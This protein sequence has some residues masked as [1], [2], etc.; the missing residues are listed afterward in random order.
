MKI[1]IAEDEAII[2]I[3]LYQVLT[4][5]GYLPI[6]PAIDSAE[7]IAAIK[8]EKPTFAIVDIH[9]GEY[10][11]GFE[12]AAVLQKQKIPFIFLTALFD[13][14]TIEQAKVY[15]PAAYL[16]KPFTKQNLFATI[17]MSNLQAQDELTAQETKTIFVKDGNKTIPINTQ[18]I[19]YL[20]AESK[21]IAIHTSTK[22]KVLI[23]SSFSE[24]LQQ[25]NFDSLVQIHK[26]FVV[27]TSCITAMK[28]DEI[29]IGD[30]NIPV[31]RAYRKNLSK[32][33]T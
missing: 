5:M 10:F 15:K 12:V 24:L 2:A 32:D 25:L 1:L 8:T 30:L 13:K 4:D 33:L 18:E 28:Y 20:E 21:Y 9:L 11:S 26:S 6:E 29:F 17:E 22:R 16:V 7:A 27:N 3:S 23:R 19:I 14:E 31:G